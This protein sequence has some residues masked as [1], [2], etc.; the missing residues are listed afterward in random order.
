MDT[1]RKNLEYAIKL[2]IFWAVAFWLM[3]HLESF[4]ATH[5]GNDPDNGGHFIGTEL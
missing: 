2:L 5:D 1:L 3:T 4:C